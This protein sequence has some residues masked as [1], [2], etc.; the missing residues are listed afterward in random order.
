MET[1]GKFER[2]RA[3]A[4]GA[5]AAIFGAGASGRAAAELLKKAG[6]GFSVYALDA[7]APDFAA[8][9]FSSEAAKS[10]RLVVY[11]PAFRPDHEWIRLAEEN[12]ARAICEPD[13]SALAW[14]G[15]IYAVTGTNGKT[16]LTSFLERALNLAGIR[17]IAAGNIG[18]PLSAFCAEIGDSSN[19]VAVCE[20]SS[21]QTSRLKFL[22]PDALLWTNFAPDH[23]DWH[24]DMREYFCA[25][26]NLVNTLRGELLF[27]S[28]DVAEAA[29]EYGM[30]MPA[31]A[32][33]PA[34]MDPSACPKPF[35][36][37]VQSRNFA[38]AAEFL[39]SLGLPYAAAEAAR[40]FPLP[41]Y[42]FGEPAEASGVKFYN[43]S[44]ATNAHAA[45]AALRELSGTESLVWF[46]GG[47]DK[48]C[49]LSE[50]AG[51]IAK[52]AK[53]AVLIGQTA[54][55]LAEILRACGVEARVCGSMKEAV[56]M[57]A[58]M[59][60]DG[61]S[62]LFSPGFSSFGMFSGYADRGKSFQN[63]VLCLKNLKEYKK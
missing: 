10:H 8:K 3:L 50:L 1:A 38:M 16:T 21:F 53:G 5:D 47:K 35:D 40:G 43:D 33:I 48:N 46:G 2:I 19:A 23:L 24:K 59:A 28:K 11:S 51:E 52:S 55:K 29:E 44:K 39:K 20:L 58:K 41:K 6:T 42:R 12:G 61:G 49:D 54:G 14:E 34:D 62:V 26:F 9:P 37:S 60:G 7:G 57:S 13:L 63:E 27:I 32:K 17:A 22:R 31:F 56:E 25:K 30:K 36:T 4:G 45:I 15:K 18:R